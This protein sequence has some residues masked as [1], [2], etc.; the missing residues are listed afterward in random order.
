LNLLFTAFIQDERYRLDIIK[1]L[2]GDVYD[3]DNPPVLR[4][5]QNI[6]SEVE[7][8]KDHIWHRYLGELTSNAFSPA[9]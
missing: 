4:K 8:N 5:M 6:V 9:F 3:D 7:Q 2:Q 1:L